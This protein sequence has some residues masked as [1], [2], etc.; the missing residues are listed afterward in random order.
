MLAAPVLVEVPRSQQVM[1]GDELIA[2]ECVVE[3]EPLVN[4]TWNV[5]QTSQVQTCTEQL[6]MVCVMSEVLMIPLVTEESVG[7]YSCLAEN[8]FG[9]AEH[10]VTISLVEERS[11]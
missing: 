8:E 2:L 7:K 3:A 1:L 10:E 6:V 4:V 9:R 5:P 11:K